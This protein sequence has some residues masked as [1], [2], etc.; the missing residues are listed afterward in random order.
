MPMRKL[1]RNREVLK[2]LQIKMFIWLLRRRKEILEGRSKKVWHCQGPIGKTEP[3]RP[4]KGVLYLQEWPSLLLSA[5]LSALAGNSDRD[6][7][8]WFDS[9]DG[10][11]STAIGTIAELC[12]A[13]LEL[14][15]NIIWWM[16]QATSCITYIYF[17]L[18]LGSILS[19]VPMGLSTW[20]ETQKRQFWCSQYNLEITTDI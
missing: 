20:Q 6:C 2:S 17:T 10:F 5:Q 7:Q 9:G 15:R 1:E 19:R 4:K 3:K 16:P 13:H 12:S 11:Q 18:Y 14:L 8:P